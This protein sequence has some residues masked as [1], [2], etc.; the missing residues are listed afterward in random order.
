M[1]RSE[2]TAAKSRD[3]ALR[4]EANDLAAYR[5]R[6]ALERLLEEGGV[7]AAADG[8]APRSAREAKPMQAAEDAGLAHGRH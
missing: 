6:K 7:E 3:F 1:K 5:Y 4:G 8:A 2:S